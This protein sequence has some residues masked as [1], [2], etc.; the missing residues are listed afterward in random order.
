MLL[1]SLGAYCLAP[2]GS[3]SSWKY[4]EALVRSLRVSGRIAYCFRTDLHFADV[5]VLSEAPVNTLAESESTLHSSGG[6]WEHLEVL[7]STSESYRSVWEVW[8][9]LP[10]RFTFC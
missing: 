1:Q 5:Q 6:G 8:V 9:W 3:G 7:R 10:D 4:L 2:G